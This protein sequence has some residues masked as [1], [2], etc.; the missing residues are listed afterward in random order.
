MIPEDVE[1]FVKVV[2]VTALIPLL[3]LLLKVVF[4]KLKPQKLARQYNYGRQEAAAVVL[5]VELMNSPANRRANVKLQM[6]VLPDRGRNF[7]AEMQEQLDANEL[8]EL[9]TGASV[10]VKF[11]PANLKEIALIR[12]RE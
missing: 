6:Q 10:K 9:R 5:K 1:I 8:A 4:K 12:N 7:V 2:L 3:M 11:N